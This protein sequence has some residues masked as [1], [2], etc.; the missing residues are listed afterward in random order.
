MIIV[1]YFFCYGYF[2]E[3]N[4]RKKNSFL[5]CSFVILTYMQWFRDISIYPDIEGYEQ[6]FDRSKYGLEI[7]SFVLFDGGY[8]IGW[9]FLNYIASHTLGTF[10]AFLKLIGILI[11]GGYL[12]AVS[13][14]SKSP[15]FSV[16]F[17]M[18]YPS[19][20]GMSFYVLKQSLAFSIILYSLKFLKDPKPY[21]Y[22]FTIFIAL[23]L[24]Y[25]AIIF[26]PLF[27]INRNINKGISLKFIIMLT[28][29]FFT[30]IRL[31]SMAVNGDLFGDKYGSY[32]DSGGNLL[33]LMLVSFITLVMF[34]NRKT[35]Y[36]T[37]N[38]EN[39]L[40]ILAYSLLGLLVCIGIYGTRMDRMALYFTNFLAISVPAASSLLKRSYGNTI[41]TAYLLFALLWVL[42]TDSYCDINHFKIL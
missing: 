35:I 23:S 42:S 38:E 14:Y 15:I 33:P 36:Y 30:G 9:F 1:C 4:S 40:I 12:Y 34:F 39:L 3:N 16:L 41:M 27:W 20:F 31:V 26:I 18:L 13:K 11:C 5:I 19:A 28:L 32:L 29:I 2:K 6:V 10:D 22:I 7:D 24:H 21:K 8:E 17:L 25:S 37:S